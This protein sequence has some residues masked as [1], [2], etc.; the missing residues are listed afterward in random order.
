MELKVKGSAVGAMYCN[1]QLSMDA[2]DVSH[3]EVM[4]Q[5][6]SGSMTLDLGNGKFTL[7]K[8][9]RVYTVEGTFYIEG[10]ELDIK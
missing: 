7:L 5:L 1:I 2:F 3:S 10:A 4:E 8:Y 6:K 9:R